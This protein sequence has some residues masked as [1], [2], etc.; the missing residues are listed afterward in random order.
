MESALWECSLFEEHGFTDLKISVKHHDPLIAVA[1]YRQLARACDYPLHLGVT[2]AGPELQGT[3]K[4]PSRSPCCW[5]RA[6][7]TRSGSRCRRRRC[8]EVKVGTQILASLGLRPR[9]LE[10]VSCPS[11][12]RAQVDVYTLADRVAA[13][14]EGLRRR[15]GSR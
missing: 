13:A 6:S 1:A 10:I 7:A 12:G 4:S 15:C 9:Q 11:C 3:V 14:F 2:E 8:E 5:P